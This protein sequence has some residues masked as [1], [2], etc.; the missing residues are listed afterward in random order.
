[1]TPLHQL[2]ENSKVWI[3][4][5]ERNFTDSELQFIEQKS[6]DFIA[7]WE[8]HGSAVK[9]HIETRYN[10]FIFI[11]ADDQNDTLCG[12]ATDSSVRFIKELES[13]LS[14]SLMDRTLLAYKENDAVQTVSFLEFQSMITGGKIT[15]E[16]VIFNNLITSKVDLINWE[17]TPQN[18]WHKQLF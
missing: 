15:E 11:Y 14:I 3:Y 1:M 16:S 9:G 6:N 8:S 12:R 5:A 18:S 10:R 17:T 13:S 2:S 7:Q 4:T